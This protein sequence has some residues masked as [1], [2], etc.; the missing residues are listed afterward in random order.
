MKKIFTLFLLISVLISCQKENF[1]PI[2][3]SNKLESNYSKSPS[4]ENEIKIKF[5]IPQEDNFSGQ[6]LFYIGDNLDSTID[7]SQVQLMD[8]LFCEDCEI[9]KVGII[10]LQCTNQQ[11]T[12]CNGW[13][14]ISAQFNDTISS[15][16][17][18]NTFNGLMTFD[19]NDILFLEP[20]FKQ[21][22]NV[23]ELNN[24]F[25]VKTL[26]NQIIFLIEKKICDY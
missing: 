26:K 12:Q 4:N 20:S 7:L 24:L 2:S 14:K 11:L 15:I 6:M 22:E 13:F 10:N 3:E 19:D 8:T 9:M 5:F 18:E 17:N 23:I 21:G 25:W 1:K 16:L